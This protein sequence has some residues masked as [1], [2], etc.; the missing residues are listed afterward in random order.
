MKTV[1]TLQKDLLIDLTGDLI[2]KRGEKEISETKDLKMKETKVSKIVGHSRNEILEVN[3]KIENTDHENLTMTIEAKESSNLENSMM[4]D[5]MISPEVQGGSEMRKV[6]DSIIEER[7]L[8][9]KDQINLTSL[10][11]SIIIMLI[12]KDSEVL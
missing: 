8:L 1:K 6:K 11:N 12:I 3:S 9:I 7:D 10:I 2:I 5:S 4:I